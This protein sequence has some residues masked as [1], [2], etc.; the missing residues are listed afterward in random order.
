MAASP[1]RPPP[2]QRRRRLHRRCSGNVGLPV[3][4][5]C[6][7]EVP[8]AAITNG[9]HLASWIYGRTSPPSRSAPRSRT[10]AS[11]TMI[12]KY[13]ARPPT[14]PQVNCRRPI[15]A[16]A[17]HGRLRR[18]RASPVAWPATPRRRGR[19]RQRFADPAVL[20]GRL[21]PP[22][23]TYRRA[24]LVLPRFCTPE[25]NSQRRGLPVQ[26]LITGRSPSKK[27][28]SS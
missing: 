24:T 12:P 16:A 17:P 25:E 26:M 2:P 22:L 19:T 3:A 13:G 20:S 28:I 7:R 11:A 21:R 4:Q 10:G 1:C 5:S 27:N 6:R 9:V 15:A 18:E 23:A 14:F 8:I